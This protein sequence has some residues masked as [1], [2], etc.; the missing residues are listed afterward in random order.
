[1]KSERQPVYDVMDKLPDV[2]FSALC[3]AMS[4]IVRVLALTVIDDPTDLM[5]LNEEMETFMSK[6]Q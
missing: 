4:G 1:M 3:Y 6:L 5:E 2:V